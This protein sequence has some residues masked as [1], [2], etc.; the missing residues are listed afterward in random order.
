M[1]SSL[2]VIGIVALIVVSA[3]PAR[4]VGAQTSEGNEPW[5]LAC[6]RMADGTYRPISFPL[7]V[8]VP[9][10]RIDAHRAHGDRYP[11]EPVPSG[12]GPGHYLDEDCHRVSFLIG[13]SLSGCLELDNPQPCLRCETANGSTSCEHDPSGNRFT[14]GTAAVRDPGI[15]FT[16]EDAAVTAD[17]DGDHLTITVA[18]GR[19]E[20]YLRFGLLD[21]NN[22]TVVG[23]PT[24]E[25]LPLESGANDL[26][27]HV[28]STEGATE[29]RS[30]TYRIDQHFPQGISEFRGTTITAVP[31]SI[32]ADG[33]AT[34]TIEV[35]LL[36]PIGNPPREE[37]NR[38]LAL[39]FDAS[40]GTLGPLTYH[41]GG[42]YTAVFTAGTT[43][44]VVRFTGEVDFLPLDLAA[45]TL[46]LTEP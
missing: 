44:G 36:D 42:R 37:Q 33:S 12:E 26:T 13:V 5:F 35:Q 30:V 11:G 29:A 7:E 4:P 39:S 31:A 46:T 9:Q 21:L 20:S 1:K 6:H 38:D 27:L 17:F 24:L 16:T 10:W 23:T 2:V 28:A 8:E 14:T 34:A 18:P 15:E 45:G 43:P 25:V 41:G 19:P 32:P 3:L 22:V 40:L